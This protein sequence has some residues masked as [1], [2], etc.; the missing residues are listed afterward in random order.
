VLLPVA[1]LYLSAP[2]QY[3]GIPDDSSI[4]GPAGPRFAAAYFLRPFTH[5][6]KKGRELIKEEKSS[7]GKS[8]NLVDLTFFPL[9]TVLIQLANLDLHKN[10]VSPARAQNHIREFLM[11]SS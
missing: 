11:T 1:I 4:G 9:E 7:D 10:I 3:Q 5:L 8:I 2:K 6:H